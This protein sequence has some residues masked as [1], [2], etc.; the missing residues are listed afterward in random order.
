MKTYEWKDGF[1][2]VWR[3]ESEIILHVYPAA[4]DILILPAASVKVC[5]VKA[6]S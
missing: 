5:D 1:K 2:K 6:P 4:F 3:E